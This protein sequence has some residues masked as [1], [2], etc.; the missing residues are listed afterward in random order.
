MGWECSTVYSISLNSFWLTVFAKRNETKWIIMYW[1]KHIQCHNSPIPLFDN[2]N[3]WNKTAEVQ[4][5]QI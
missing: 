4:N 2:L 5:M 3:N 1:N